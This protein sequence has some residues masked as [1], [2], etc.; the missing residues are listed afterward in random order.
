MKVLIGKKIG[1]T[2]LFLEDGT[3]R[4]VTLLDVSGNKVAKVLKK[5]EAKTHVVIAKGE[6]KNGNKP[7]KEEF[8]ELGFVPTEKMS[9]KIADLENGETLNVGDDLNASIFEGVKEV[10]TTSKTKGKGFQGVVRRWGFA[11]GPRTHGASDRER[12]PGSIGMRTI[13]GR[14]FKGKKMSGHMGTR[15]KTIQGLRVVRIDSEKNIIALGGA[16]PGTKGDTVII[17]SK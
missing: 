12:A 1:M 4:P 15:T 14:V 11:G 16:I 9:V 3:A 6:K 8:K 17:K 5:G 2:Q 13:P 7:M 10:S